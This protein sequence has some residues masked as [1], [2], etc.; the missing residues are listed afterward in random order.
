MARRIDSLEDDGTARRYP[1]VEWTQED[2]IWEIRRGEDYDVAT[3]NMRVNL[4]ERANYQNQ[5]VTTRKVAG[6][7]WEGLRF[8]FVGPPMIPTPDGKRRLT[9]MPGPVVVQRD[10]PHAE[11]WQELPER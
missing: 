9:P 11:D 4:H 6:A 7:D 5:R 1:W 8:Q 10:G 2:T 3:E